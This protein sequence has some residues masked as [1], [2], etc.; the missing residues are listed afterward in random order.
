LNTLPPGSSEE[1]FDSLDPL[2]SED[3]LNWKPLSLQVRLKIDNQ[4]T[5]VY[6]HGEV[7]CRGSFQCDYGLEWFEDSLRGKFDLVASF[8]HQRFEEADDD[9]VML[10]ETGTNVLDFSTAVRDTVMLAIPIAHICGPDC[11]SGKTL[12]A[13]LAAPE[14]PDERWEKLKD[15]FK[16]EE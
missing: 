14:A 11:P 5:T 7:S 8:D 6:L 12:Q 2:L 9:E 10:L 3:D 1:I 4:G 15:L 13:Q 16:E